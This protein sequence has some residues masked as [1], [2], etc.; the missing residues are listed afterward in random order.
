[1][2]PFA[3]KTKSAEEQELL[4]KMHAEITKGPLYFSP[5]VMKSLKKA[6]KNVAISDD[7]KKKL[8]MR[9]RSRKL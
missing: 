7:F 1:M 9:A 4:D 6:V 2:F 5:V 3:E 8:Q